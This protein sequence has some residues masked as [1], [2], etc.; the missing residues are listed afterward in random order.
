MKYILTDTNGK[1]VAFEN[2]VS[3]VLDKDEAAVADALTLVLAC[4]VCNRDFA[5]VCVE[6]KGAVIFK[7]I[8]DEQTEMQTTAAVLI[9][10]VAR[11]MAAILLDNEALPQ[12]YYKPSMD[13]IFKRHIQPLGFQSYIGENRILNGELHITKGM[14]VWQILQMFQTCCGGAEPKVHAD[15]I[16]DVSDNP[17][18]QT[19]ILSPEIIAE[20]THTKKRYAVIS[21]VYTRGRSGAGYEIVKENPLA[22]KLNICRIRYLNAANTVS[23]SVNSSTN[24]IVQGNRMYEYTEMNCVGCILYPLGTKVIVEG[25]KDGILTA[26]TYQK[27]M[28]GETTALTVVHENGE[29]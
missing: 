6:D 23:S 20:R 4:D 14:S 8:V 11:S 12:I 29:G 24:L 3:V 16:I 28:N 17:K 19:V 15:G 26:L 27:N 5:F 2:A 22:E 7:G 21:K 9:E 18:E 10:I 13:E 1:T 25:Q